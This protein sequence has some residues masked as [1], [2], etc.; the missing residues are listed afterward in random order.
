MSWSRHGACC[1][2]VVIFDMMAVCPVV[3]EVI[4]A[5]NWVVH[6]TVTSIAIVVVIDIVG[7]VSSAS[8]PSSTIGVASVVV[9][10]VGCVVLWL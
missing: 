8:V 10:I 1:A 7:V 9:V 4:V 6:L 2:G 3:V 5:T